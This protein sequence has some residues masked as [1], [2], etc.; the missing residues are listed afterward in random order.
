MHD[1]VQQLISELAIKAG[2]LSPDSATWA[3]PTFTSYW[4]QRFSTALW[5]ENAQLAAHIVSKCLLG[6]RAEYG[7]TDEDAAES[8]QDQDELQD[9]IQ[10]GQ[11]PR[12]RTADEQQEEADELEKF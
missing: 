5:R 4:I 10:G 12:P 2:H 3:A 9:L 6:Y 1:G 11:K 8:P 7:V